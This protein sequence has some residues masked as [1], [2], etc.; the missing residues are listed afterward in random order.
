MGPEKVRKKILV[1]DDE[2]DMMIFLRTL[3][4]TGGFQSIGAENGAEGLKMAREET[5]AL[6]ILDIMMPQEGGVQMFCK[7]KQDETLKN[8]PVIML[9]AIERKT[10]FHY[11]KFFGSTPR[12][13]S[14]EVLQQVL[15]HV[16]S[17]C[18]T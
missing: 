12:L 15:H 6:I 3:L 4:D 2:S 14:S 17:C 8:I 16:A 5:P 11:L 13:D 7:L 9:S 10:F 1:V 18:A